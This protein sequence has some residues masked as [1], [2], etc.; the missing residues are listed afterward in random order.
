MAI[1]SKFEYFDTFYVDLPTYLYPFKF[2]PWNE[3]FTLFMRLKETLVIV[4]VYFIS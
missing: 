1:L 4:V 2:C 3:H